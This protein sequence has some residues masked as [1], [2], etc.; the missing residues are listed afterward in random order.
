VRFGVLFLVSPY[1]TFFFSSIFG[2]GGCRVAGCELV[3]VS[4]A[5][6][7]GLVG[8]ALLSVLPKCL[9][10]VLRRITCVAAGEFSFPY[11]H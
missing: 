8:G 3:L 9:A 4:L 1:R 11:E 5:S 2:D 7:D 6:A 10:E